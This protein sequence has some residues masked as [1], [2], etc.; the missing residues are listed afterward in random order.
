MKN[1]P[2]GRLK[3][4][5]GQ[6]TGYH[7]QGASISRVWCKVLGC[8][9]SETRKIMEGML[10]VM[11]LN[12]DAR[13]ATERYIEN[14]PDFYLA[15]FRQIEQLCA[16]M[17]MQTPMTSVPGFPN[18]AMIVSLTFMEHQLD[19]YFGATPSD[20]EAQIELLLQSVD[21]LLEECLAATMNDKLKAALVRQLHSIRTALM[22]YKI[23][24]PEGLEAAVEQ[25]LGSLFRHQN[26]VSEHASGDTKISRFV[27]LLGRANDL[28]SSYQ[29]IAPA[30]APISTLFLLS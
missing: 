15:P 25:A 10:S 18:D 29:L 8:E 7:N 16:H 14:C 9:P 28:A 17:Q 5:M 30:L 23:T 20:Q 12:D 22:T 3:D 26:L 2:V 6:F 21:E 1:N 13:A 24:G 4:T 27:D 11:K 19:A